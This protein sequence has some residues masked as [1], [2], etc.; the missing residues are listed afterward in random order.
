MSAHREP[1][2][3]PLPAADQALLEMVRWLARDG[4]RFTTATP[5]THARV[6]A[7]G[8]NAWARDLAGVFGWS[9]PFREALL[10]PALFG[11]MRD[12]GILA[13]EE[14]GWRCRLRV[15]SVGA[16][17]YLHSAYPT[18]DADAVFL[19][20]D[21]YRYAAALA[22]HLAALERPLRR[23][24]DIGCGA[25]VAAIAMAL[26]Q[27]RAEVHALDINEAALRL[28]RINALLAGAGNLTAGISDLLGGVTGSFDL[29]AANPPYLVDPA[30]R[31]YRNGG[32]PLG[33]GLSLAIVD[34]ALERL[35]P[36]GTLL[37]YTGVAIVDG[38]DPFA[39]AAQA[40]LAAAGA[41]WTYEEI[42]PDVF[43]EELLCPAYAG[44]D[45]IAAVVLK[46]VRVP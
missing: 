15:S 37:L 4:Y 28:T 23:V 8:E 32:G 40:R 39:A 9:R 46:A 31:A 25:G 24:A 13:Q 7:R 44:T 21:T 16:N 45:R 14:D 1:D 17:L 34:A 18:T 35:A 3:N 29:I 26:A 10:A 27:P 42:D 36:G 38:A 19:G 5:A 41:A 20:P 2:A 11:L 12:A 22:R 30:E 33:A 43:G 6:N